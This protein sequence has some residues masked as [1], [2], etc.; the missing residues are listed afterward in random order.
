MN[1]ELW[2]MLDYIGKSVYITVFII[3]TAICYLILKRRYGYKIRN[4]FLR[5]VVL[6]ISSIAISVTVIEIIRIVLNYLVN[7]V[8]RV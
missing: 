2:I 5:F 6:L 1:D 3:Y 7:I 8:I 4:T